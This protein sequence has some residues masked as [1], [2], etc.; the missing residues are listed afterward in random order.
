MPKLK[1]IPEM[2]AIFIAALAV[3]FPAFA[4]YDYYSS[5][6]FSF[7]QNNYPD[8]S[9]H[10][11]KTPEDT[12]EPTRETTT[13]PE[14]SS[15]HSV[16]PDT[17]DTSSLPV[18]PLPYKRDT[19]LSDDI[20]ADFLVELAG[21]GSANEVMQ[22]AKT[23]ARYDFV[24]VYA[25]MAQQ[26]GLDSAS[27]DGLIALWYG[28]AWAIA[29]QKP[30]PTAKQYQ[31]IAKQMRDTNANA[32]TWSKMDNRARQTFIEKLAYPFIIQK[33]N[34]VAYKRDGKTA[35]VADMASHVQSGMIKFDINMQSLQLTDAGF[36][37]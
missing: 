34:Y 10:K 1:F 23:M 11:W 19:A 12:S 20:R 9:E 26:Q 8:L 30:L 6:D 2:I 25:G 31:A 33:A 3:P 7:N 18:S 22:M 13:S 21:R 36:R 32:G 5:G 4:Q 15:N 35:A 14:Q 16:K 27:A 28:Q 29:N 24:Q 17:V 37:E